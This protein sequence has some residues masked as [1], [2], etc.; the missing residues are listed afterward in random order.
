MLKFEKI[1]LFSANL[2]KKD[3]IPDITA[4]KNHLWFIPDETVSEKEREFIGVGM[5]SSVL[6]YKMQNLYDR[7]FCNREYTAAILENDSLRAV[8]LPELGGRLWSLYDK[9]LKKDIIYK[10]DALIFANLAL[11]NAWFAGGVEWNVG[12]RGHTYF[13]CAPLFAVK[14]NGK[15]GNHILRMYEYEEIR[16]LVFCI[17]AT[18]DGDKL[19]INITVKNT[20]S[21]PTYMYWW[22]NIA[23]EQKPGTKFFVPANCSFVTSYRD[24][25]FCISKVDVPHLSGKDV[26]DPYHAY[27]AIDYFFDIP[28]ENK[29]W[30]SSIGDDGKGLLQYSDKRL[31]GR[32]AFLWGNIPGGQHWNSWLTRGR[33][34]YEIQAGLCKTQF[35]HFLLDGQDEISWFEV[36]RGIDIGSN[37]GEWSEITAK[38]DAFVP[39]KLDFSD[40]FAE[41]CVDAPA[42]LG[43]GKGYLTEKIRDTRLHEKCYFPK[44]SVGEEEKYYLDLLN[45]ISTDADENTEFIAGAEWRALIESRSNLTAFDKYIL[46]LICYRDAEYSAARKYLEESV[47]VGEK[48]YSLAALGL[49]LS[50]VFGECEK[51]L[52]CLRRAVELASNN[53]SLVVKY[54]EIAIKCGEFNEFISFYSSASEEI[55]NIGR[56]KMYVGQCLVEIGETERA[57]EFINSELVVEDFKEGEYS[58]SGIWVK[59]Y[60]KEMAKAMGCGEE[61][62]SDALVLC[63]HPLPYD[64]D[65]RM[66]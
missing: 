38:I 5:V 58:V 62:I 43:R 44:E 28:D 15:C 16:G 10:N 24:G 12:V 41:G 17:E 6:P 39:E 9:K 31:F 4:P 55:K 7:S 47:A 2:G 63:E 25:G 60:K 45:G 27:D 54:G 14:V 20:K 51:A 36:Y 11:R 52:L 34:Y 37:Q 49:L 1:E 64:I 42:I 40:M 48:Y 46:A 50:N 59:L 66:H 53:P 21:E 56:L 13:T 35:E 65:F 61:D 29:K 26:S 22:S 57:K 18:L 32:K 33:D 8:F 3:N 23:V 30:I 19:L